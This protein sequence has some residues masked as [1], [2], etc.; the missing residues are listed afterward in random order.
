[1][2]S[3]QFVEAN[4]KTFCRGDQLK[5]IGKID[6][7]GRRTTIPKGSNSLAI[8]IYSA[9]GGATAYYCQVCMVKV[10]DDMNKCLQEANSKV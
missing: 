6:H 2:A 1:M 9:S 4:G 5:C 10:L 3:F 8:S 7:Y